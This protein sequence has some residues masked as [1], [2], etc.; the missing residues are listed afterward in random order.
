LHR[1]LFFAAPN[2]GALN[3]P[4][5]FSPVFGKDASSSRSSPLK[6]AFVTMLFAI[7]RNIEVVNESRTRKG[8]SGGDGGWRRIASCHLRILRAARIKVLAVV[9]RKIYPVGVYTNGDGGGTR[10]ITTSEVLD[11]FLCVERYPSAITRGIRNQDAPSPIL[12]QPE[13]GGGNRAFFLPPQKKARSVTS[14]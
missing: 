9:C 5:F 11:S 12:N 10:D 13:K 3:L 7:T 8:A 6:T 1:R 14:H 4:P 2:H